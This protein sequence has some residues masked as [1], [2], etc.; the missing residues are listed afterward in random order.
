MRTRLKPELEKT[1]GAWLYRGCHCIVDPNPKRRHGVRFSYECDACG[2]RNLRYIHTLEHL[3]TERQIEVG[4][5][6]ARALLGPEDESLPGLAENETKRKER[7]RIHYHR[8]GLC[9]TTEDDLIERG[10]L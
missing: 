9:M 8:P 6:C 2:N 3:D 4:I 5:E 7:W 10:K 1:T